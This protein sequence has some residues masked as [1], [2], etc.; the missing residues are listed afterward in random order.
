MDSNAVLCFYTIKLSVSMIPVI[1]ELPHREQQELI[2][3]SHLLK[4]LQNVVVY[5]EVQHRLRTKGQRV[6]A[7]SDAVVWAN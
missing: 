2:T 7:E 3:Q 1:P 6:S 5:L 4:V